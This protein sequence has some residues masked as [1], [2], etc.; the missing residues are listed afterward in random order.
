MSNMSYCRW[1][2]TLPDLQDCYDS[3]RE[4]PLSELSETEHESAK[5]MMELAKAFVQEYE[6]EFK[7]SEY[8]ENY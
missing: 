3:L 7:N 5:E 2:N 1:E 8:E 6:D 4:T